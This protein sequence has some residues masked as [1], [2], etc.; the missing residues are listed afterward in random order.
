MRKIILLSVALGLFTF[1]AAT[2]AQPGIGGWITLPSLNPARFGHTATRLADGRVLVA[3]GLD[4]VAV[5]SDTDIFDPASRTWTPAADMG[6]V[7]ANHTATLLPDGRVLVA[8]GHIDHAATPVAS[9]EVYDPASDTWTPVPSMADSRSNHT[10][11]LLTDGQVLIAAGRL[12]PGVGSPLRGTELFD[13]AADTWRSVGDMNTFH[14]NWEGALLADGRVLLAGGTGPS[15]QAEVY[16]PASESWTAA[17]TMNDI[18]E[19]HELTVLPDGSVLATGGTNAALAS[20]EVYTPDTWTPVASMNTGRTNHTATLLPNGSV[21]VAAGNAAGAVAL[22]GTEIYDPALDTWAPGPD[23]NTARAHSTATL[24]L[25]G[26]VMVVGGL[27]DSGAALASVDLYDPE[28]CV[29]CHLETIMSEYVEG[30]VDNKAI[31]IYNGTCSDLDLSAELFQIEIYFNGHSFSESTIPLV[32][33]LVAGDVFVLADDGATFPSDQ[34][35]TY[36]FFNGNDAVVLRRGG[37]LVDSIGR[38]GENPG[39]E[40]FGGGIGTKEETLRRKADVWQGDADELD[41]FD[42]S[43][44][45]EGFPRDTFDGL[46]S[47]TVSCGSALFI[48]G[49]PGVPAGEDVAVPIDFAGGDI[50]AVAFSVDYDEGCLSFDATDGDGD[51][52]PDAIGF[53]APPAFTVAVFFDSGDTDGEIDILI[54]DLP[55]VATLPNGALAT[56][57]FGSTCTPPPGSK[58]LAPVLFS[59][60]PAASFGNTA[61]QDVSGI[62]VGAPVEIVPADPRGDVNASGNVGAGDITALGLEIFDGDGSFWLDTF[63][64]T[65]LGSPAGSDSNVDTWVDAGD[66]SCTS[67]LIFGLS[68]GGQRIATP[69][70]I[71]SLSL[72]AE[73]RASPSGT[74]VAPI[75]FSARGHAISSVVFSLDFDQDLLIFD[76]FDGDQDGVPDAVHF[77]SGLSVESVTFNPD[78]QQG[79]LDFLITD[80]AGAPRALEDGLLVEVEL[81]LIQPAGTVTSVLFSAEPRASFGDVSGRSV[82]G[83]TEMLRGFLFADGFEAGNLSAWTVAVP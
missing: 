34:T 61:G 19:G 59:S 25:D 3:G 65:F 69:T 33:T 50:A 71:P 40:W 13:P 44:E 30:S 72:E 31:E 18:R 45:W 60:D 15:R 8:G 1:S 67:R 54:F 52:L 83:T 78:D 36:N 38:V 22:S 16:D 17:D 48:P 68:C 63:G 21:L 6:V 79:E 80:L 41:P 51:G 26:R 5:F 10:A 77:N 29:P 2:V 53:H 81:Q 7:R 12:G 4:D 20:A 46:G 32:G 62:A 42:P 14:W 73:L 66:V 27:D 55:P 49:R 47:H 37:S 76:D 23:M 39:S 70:G 74:V 11:L 9:A 35:S 64:G 57:T 56:I 82:S 43:V 75:R 28:Y 24:L 58:I